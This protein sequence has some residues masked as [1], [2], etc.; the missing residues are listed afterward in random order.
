MESTFSFS[1][2]I[3]R[4]GVH[5]P[6]IPK[7]SYEL[8][9]LACFLGI[10]LKVTCFVCGSFVYIKLWSGV[11]ISMDQ[12]CSIKQQWVENA[13]FNQFEYNSALLSTRYG[14]TLF[15]FWMVCTGIEIVVVEKNSS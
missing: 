11:F 12:S 9:H 6:W 5:L 3:L 8:M 4:K 1:V 15:E 2:L 7:L 14:G 10:S 13:E